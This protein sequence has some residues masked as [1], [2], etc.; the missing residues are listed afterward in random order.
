MSTTSGLN[1]RVLNRQI[2]LL[3]LVL[4]YFEYFTRNIPF[5]LTHKTDEPEGANHSG[6]DQRHG[7]SAL[8]HQP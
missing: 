4:V 6:R 3:L 5:L 1:F 7:C 8:S 2:L